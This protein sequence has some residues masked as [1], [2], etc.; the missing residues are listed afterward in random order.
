[1]LNNCPVPSINRVFDRF[2]NFFIV[3]LKKVFPIIGGKYP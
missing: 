2:N 1:M 3:K